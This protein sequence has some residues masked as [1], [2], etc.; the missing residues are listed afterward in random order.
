VL[1]IKNCEI[2]Q[3]QSGKGW[4]V[5]KGDIAIRNDEIVGLGSVP[6]KAARQVINGTGKIALPG[7]VNAHYH[8]YANLIRTYG[9]N[10]PLETWMYYAFLAGVMDP[11]DVY[12]SAMLGCIEMIKSGITTVLDHLN[13]STGSEGLEAALRAYEV[14]GMR[15]V[16]SPMVSDKFYYKTLP[17][18]DGDLP[19]QMIREFEAIKPKS[20]AYIVTA[21][22]NLIQKW[23]GKQN[24]L[25]GILLGPSGPQRCSD[26]LL[27]ALNRLATKYGLGLHSHLVET[28]NQ[29][30]T[31]YDNYGC[32]MVEYMERLGLLNSRWSFA[33]SVWVSDEDIRLMGRNRVSVVHNPASNLSIGSGIA[34][35]NKLR[36]SGVN[37]ALGTDGSNSGGNL[38]LFRSMALAAMLAKITTP[39]HEDWPRSGEVL[40]MATNGGA[41]AL[42]MEDRIGTLAVGKKADVIL[43]DGRTSLL[44]PRMNLP[45]QLV[46][47][48]TGQ[49]VDTSIIG[50]K[51]VMENRKITTFNEA[52]ILFNAQERYEQLTR[53]L[54]PAILQAER[55][56]PYIE[57]VY[58]REIRRPLP[59]HRSAAW[60]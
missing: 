20:A 59:F 39:N 26:E 1:L 53:K 11:E 4:D 2:L 50:G 18:K 6:D 48:E 29:A 38:S 34:P 14:A 36:K 5:A 21:C 16:M 17:V 49:S 54:R 60:E 56:I 51:V 52:E 8:S 55:Q 32:S 9:E 23:H 13:F 46:Y 24:G 58:R 31:A 33:H 37:V 7:L 22:E 43:L 40:A 45:H 12:I 42:Q 27:I 41:K 57:K 15:A 44:V 25:L 35:I 28:K 10:Q 19:P 30:V 47:S 3:Y